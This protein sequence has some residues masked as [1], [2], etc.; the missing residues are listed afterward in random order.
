MDRVTAHFV[1]LSALTLAYAAACD[2]SHPSPT[3]PTPPARTRRL[4]LMAPRSLAP[5]ATAQLRLVA[6]WSDGVDEDVT[7]TASFFSNDPDVLRVSS[8]GM[9][10]ALTRGEAVVSWHV[11]FSSGTHEIVVVPAGTY[12]VVGR[13]SVETEPSVAVGG[14]LVESDGV[15]ETFTDFSGQYRLYGVAA[16]GRLRISKTAYVTREIPLAISDH[17]TENIALTRSE[18]GAIV[19]ALYQMTIEAGNECRGQIPEPLLTRRYAAAITQ[20][21]SEIRVVLT[22]ARFFP[23]FVGPSDTTTIP[24]FIY[25]PE[26][27]LQLDLAWPTHCEGTEP[28]SRVVEIINDTTYLEISGSG[29]LLRTGDGFAGTFRGL[30]LTRIS[31]LCGSPGVV[32]SSCG[33]N[34]SYRVTLTR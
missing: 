32:T 12:R 25:Q 29:Q 16:H 5:G 3:S 23:D 7:R 28:D 8:A 4:E 13:V 10:D 6:H 14:A 33:Q 18:P 26:G 1:L 30:Y 19:E 15:P 27:R 20:K 2:R 9:V 11:E 21:E 17:H 31:P 22:G 24:G 34:A